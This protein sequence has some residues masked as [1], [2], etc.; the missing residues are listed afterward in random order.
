ML[1]SD[2]IR[3]A[4][5]SDISAGDFDRWY[6]PVAELQVFCDL[7]SLPGTGTKADLRT[8]VLAKLA[9]AEPP[10]R[11]RR[12]KGPSW[13]KVQITPET[14]VTENISFGPNVR[15]YFKS[16]IGASFVCH[17]DFMD[18]MRSNAGATFADAVAAW[19][20]L[21]ARKEDPAFRR[22]I[23]SCNNYLQ[24]LRDLR[25]AHPNISLDDAKRCWDAKKVRPAMDGMVIYEPEDLRFLA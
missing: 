24:Y 14:V 5:T 9:G 21:E 17:G 23:A 10:K 19:Q 15:G 18:W 8:R 1:D 7:L 2:P 25:D 22:E 20:M 16:V 13:G 6:W 12:P 4:P 3:P 11:P